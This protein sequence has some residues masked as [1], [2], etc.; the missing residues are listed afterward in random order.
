VLRAVK[1]P[2]VVVV[3]LAMSIMAASATPALAGSAGGG[4]VDISGTAASH[5]LSPGQCEIYG[6]DGSND[7]LLV[8]GEAQGGIVTTGV[9][10]PV[11]GV[12]EPPTNEQTRPFRNCNN[13]YDTKIPLPSS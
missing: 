6:I 11:P 1:R 12:K 13:L 10:I 2:V 4:N 7:I 9:R 5:F 3:L 8:K